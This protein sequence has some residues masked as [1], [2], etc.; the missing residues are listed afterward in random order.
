MEC[1]RWRDAL[2]AMA[3]GES[4]DID[5]RLVAAHVARCPGC[6]AYKEMIEASPNFSRIDVAAEMPD[7]S[8]S[9]S[10]LNAAADRAAHWSIL[11]I[12]LAVVAVQ[13]IAFALP[14]LLLGEENGIATHSARHLGAFGVAYGVALMVVVVRPA[15]ARSILP[16]AMVLAGA[17]VLG[18]IVD[19]ATG[20]IP[21]VGEARHLPQIISVFLIWFLAVPT[22]R[23]RR[24]KPKPGD[25][26]RLKLVD[27]ERRAG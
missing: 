13:V 8:K 18:A 11:R 9:I 3:D 20:R 15:R 22:E 2:S 17:Q 27:D 23:R 4:A 21:L 19:L 6:Q 14:A 24:T 10:K 1:S 25:R 7:M 16:V 12:V 5:E 26:P